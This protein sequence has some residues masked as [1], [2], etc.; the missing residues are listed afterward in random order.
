MRRVDGLVGRGVEPEK[1]S[2]VEYEAFRLYNM[3]SL[4]I[5]HTVVVSFY[6]NAEMQL[7]A[8]SIRG[9]PACLG[10]HGQ[11]LYPTNDIIPLIRPHFQSDATM[12]THPTGIVMHE[13][14]YLVKRRPHP[15]GM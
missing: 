12:P 2:A 15:V 7:V 11:F 14:L 5:L 9:Y 8:C 6:P 1:L 3:F 4:S 13:M 10:D